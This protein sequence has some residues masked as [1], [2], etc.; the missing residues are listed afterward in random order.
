MGVSVG[1]I[2]VLLGGTGVKVGVGGRG[3]FVGVVWLVAPPQPAKIGK[4][5]DRL[6]RITENLFLLMS[7]S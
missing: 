3:V 7:T 6:I 2:G 1:G 5:I 4:T